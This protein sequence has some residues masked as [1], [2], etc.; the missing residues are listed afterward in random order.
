M[1]EFKEWL[2]KNDERFPVEEK[3]FDLTVARWLL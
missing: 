2:E 3:M 1:T